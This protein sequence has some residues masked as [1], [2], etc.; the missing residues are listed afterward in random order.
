M[1]KTFIVVVAAAVLAL[2]AAA[3]L[4]V[5]PH[6][7]PVAAAW[8]PVVATT[9]AQSVAAP[10][11]EVAVDPSV[12]DTPQARAYLER[13]DFEQ[14]A[15]RFFADPQAFAPEAR[16]REAQALV[17]AIDRYEHANQLSAG[18]AMNL[19]I[20]LVRATVDDELVQV[21]RIA[22]IVAMYRADG[23]RRE[24]RWLEQQR[25]DAAFTEYKAREQ[26]IVAQVMAL[27]TIPDGLTRE[28]Y[29]RQRLQAERV[30]LSH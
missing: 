22:D 21:D 11:R 16:E 23:E 30:A 12:L 10:E 1:N 5:E 28:E 4:R 2:S 18:E 13:A 6:A 24:A 3:W 8:V 26:A 20:G 9:P 19:R 27:A 7:R 17:A 25:G 15:R 29:L 14:R